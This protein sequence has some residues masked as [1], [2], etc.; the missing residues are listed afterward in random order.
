MFINKLSALKAAIFFCILNIST[1]AFCAP[2][3]INS[4][5]AK[6]IANALS[7][8]GI[9]KAQ[10]I[11][12]YRNQHGD[13]SSADELVNIKGIGKKTIEKNLDDIQL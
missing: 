6:E 1:L 11:V 9:K 4:A 3:D 8:I 5:T 7:G 13:F 2:V 10:A 12:E